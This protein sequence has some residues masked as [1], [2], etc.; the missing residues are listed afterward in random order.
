V[1]RGHG[2]VGRPRVPRPGI[3]ASMP[4]PAGVRHP[5]RVHVAGLAKTQ[6]H[7]H[8]GAQCYDEE[9]EIGDFFHDHGCSVT[10]VSLLV[11]KRSGRSRGF[12]FVDLD[13]EASFINACAVN[14]L[15]HPPGIKLDEKS[16]GRIQVS[17]AKPSDD[18]IREKHLELTQERN[19][20]DGLEKEMRLCAARINEKMQQIQAQRDRQLALQKTKK[21]EEELHNQRARQREIEELMQELHAIESSLTKEL[22]AE[23]ERTRALEDLHAN[24]HWDEEHHVHEHHEP[25]SASEPSRPWKPLIVPEAEAL[26]RNAPPG[27]SSTRPWIAKRDE[28]EEALKRAAHIGQDLSRNILDAKVEALERSE[29]HHGKGAGHKGGAES[30]KMMTPDHPRWGD[31]VD[32]DNEFESADAA[33][34]IWGRGGGRR[35]VRIR[36]LPDL[37]PDE[38]KAELMREF[39]RLWKATGRDTPPDVESIRV[40]KYD[41]KYVGKLAIE[42]LVVFRDPYNAWLLVEH[43]GAQDWSSSCTPTLHGQLLQVEWPPKPLRS[44][45]LDFRKFNFRAD[46]DASSQISYNTIGTA[47]SRSSFIA[48]KKGSCRRSASADSIAD[49]VPPQNRTVIIAGVPMSLNAPSV[50]VELVSILQSAYRRNGYDFD[51][52]IHL[53]KGTAGI[54]V[55]PARSPHDHN[56]GTVKLRF[57]SY[58]DAAW[59]VGQAP[60]LKMTGSKLKAFWAQPRG[61]QDAARDA[62]TGGYPSGAKAGGKGAIHV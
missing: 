46:T 32:D 7:R 42:A 61:A 2:I 23:K 13:D 27:A 39:A 1:G 48:K 29:G 45:P 60:A 18:S 57:R 59:L 47:N 12:A 56:G 4:P 9:Y 35:D 55:R 43:C 3:M 50:K 52:K 15:D 44:I 49:A 6:V 58:A 41:A 54:E 24:V 31:I 14:G 8:D 25:H 20:T 26:H 40:S 30:H 28:K 16:G 21:V 22:K 34:S 11:D 33:T 37:H 19:R 62:R 36:N 53:H 51:P 10:W 5:Y 17:P 38:L